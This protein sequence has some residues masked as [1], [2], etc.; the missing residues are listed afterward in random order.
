MQLQEEV[1]LIS[2][3]V[4]RSVFIMFQGPIDDAGVRYLSFES[5]KLG[6]GCAICWP[7][8]R[9]SRRDRHRCEFELV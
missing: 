7:R 2:S 4:V 1:F 8:F 6:A 3:E 5:Q 9:A